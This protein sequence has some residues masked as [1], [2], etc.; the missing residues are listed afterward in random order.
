M[1][2]RHHEGV[3]PSDAY[4]LSCLVQGKPIVPEEAARL[5]ARGWIDV[6][7]GVH[8]ITLAGRAVIDAFEQGPGVG[9]RAS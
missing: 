9:A 8:L 7:A 3:A 6:H 2:H 4:A 5:C 1:R